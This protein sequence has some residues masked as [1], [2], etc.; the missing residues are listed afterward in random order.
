LVIH[1]IFL[2]NF[3]YFIFFAWS[4]V[5][6]VKKILK[7]LGKVGWFQY[8]TTP[9]KNKGVS[10]KNQ[11]KKFIKKR[12]TK[13]FGGPDTMNELYVYTVIP[14]YLPVPLTKL[15]V[16]FWDFDQIFKVPS[17]NNRIIFSHFE[18]SWIWKKNLFNLS[19]AHAFQIKGN[20]NQA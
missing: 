16:Q 18:N 8:K 19:A 4:K 11:N 14:T 13:C 5:G 17:F 15:H 1:Q 3:V 6:L 2:Q 10:Q 7:R 20:R 12:I 9:Q